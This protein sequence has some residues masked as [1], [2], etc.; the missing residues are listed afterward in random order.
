[1]AHDLLFKSSSRN[2]SRK[3]ENEASSPSFI[4]T[5][6]VTPT[7]V[8]TPPVVAAPAIDLQVKEKIDQLAA[9]KKSAE[10]GDKKAAKKWSK[11][12]KKVAKIQK[13]ANKGDASAVSQIATGLFPDITKLSGSVGND[14]L[15]EI[16]TS[17][18]FVGRD[19]ILGN[20]K[21]TEIIT[22]GEF[23][24]HDEILGAFIGDDKL[25][26]IITSGEFVGE[27]ELALAKEGGSCERNALSRRFARHHHH[28]RHPKDE[29]DAQ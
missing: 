27:E 17:G 25:T 16:I 29:K 1:M 4:P 26:E 18:E 6:V 11:I 10:S 15:T 2:W 14:K 20:D 24:G 28:H 21:L 9:I 3:D 5:P 23:V 7:S 19:E 13:K 22:S 8:A 12:C